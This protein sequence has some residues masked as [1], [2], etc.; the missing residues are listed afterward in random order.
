MAAQEPSLRLYAILDAESCRRK[1][2]D[3]FETAKALHGGGVRL[4]QYRDKSAERSEYLRNARQ[5]RSL[6]PDCIFLLN[7]RADLVP[8]AEADGV[9]VGQTDVSPDAARAHI[10]PDRILGIST[11]TGDQALAAHS[12][13]AD[14]LAIGPVFATVSKQNAEPTVGLCG[15]QAARAVTQK[16]LVAIGGIGLGDARAV[17]MAGADSIAVISALLPSSNLPEIT[18]RAQDFLARLK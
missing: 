18:R 4:L 3:L 10:G 16:P 7:D 17:E 1:H 5:L 2:L 13:E 12:T 14:Y 6:L 8:E 11:H 9:H 15:V